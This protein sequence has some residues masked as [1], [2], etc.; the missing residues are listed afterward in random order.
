MSHTAIMLIAALGLLI[1]L[2]LLVRDKSRATCAFLALWLLVS[3]AN[4]LY[5]V[6]GA[7]YGWGEEAVVWLFVFGLPA[8]VALIAAR[9]GR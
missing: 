1:G 5:G 7:G 8:A 4:L 6:L 3:I 9:V 2:R